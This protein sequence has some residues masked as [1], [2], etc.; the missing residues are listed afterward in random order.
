MAFSVTIIEK[1]TVKIYD[2]NDSYI[3][4]RVQGF[5]KVDLDD[6]EEHYGL[7][8]DADAFGLTNLNA[9]FIQSIDVADTVN[10]GVFFDWDPDTGILMAFT[11]GAAAA[12]GALD[13]AEA[14]VM[15]WGS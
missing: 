4:E 14:I 8:L 1:N 15:F 12:D 3:G 10:A 13:G 6:Y 11:G 5:A 9:L 2:L 7:T